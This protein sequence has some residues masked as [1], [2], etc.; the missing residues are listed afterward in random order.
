MGFSFIISSNILS[1]KDNKFYYKKR[2]RK[3]EKRGRKEGK[4]VRRK[5]RERKEGRER[6]R[7]TDY[8]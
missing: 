1:D 2:G 7:K 5:K 4:E 3:E 8:T 6:Q